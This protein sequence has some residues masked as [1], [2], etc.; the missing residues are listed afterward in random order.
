MLHRLLFVVYIFGIYKQY[1]INM[2]C[3]ALKYD[4]YERIVVIL[5]RFQFMFE[6]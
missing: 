2:S 3:L 4:N 1:C 5:G 6:F